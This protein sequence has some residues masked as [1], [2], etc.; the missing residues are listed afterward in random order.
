MAA[1][2]KVTCR[3]RRLWLRS[4]PARFVTGIGPELGLDGKQQPALRRVVEADLHIIGQ[5]RVGL[6]VDIEILA[7][8]DVPVVGI[9]L[10]I[11]TGQ[12]E[13]SFIFPAG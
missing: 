11:E 8:H 5:R 12:A 2:A 13:A 1:R 7:L 3:P 10:A 4:R 9:R 6:L